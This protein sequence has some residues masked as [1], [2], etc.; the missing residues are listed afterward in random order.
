MLANSL[1]RVYEFLT[2][3][4]AD[5]QSAIR[6]PGALHYVNATSLAKV[7]G[8]VPQLGSHQ[9]LCYCV[10][11]NSLIRVYGFLTPRSADCQTAG[12]PIPKLHFLRS[13]L[14]S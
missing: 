13:R 8:M 12:R 2:P 5:C 10:L 6:M 9:A 1:I 14:D 11:A 4:V 3:R 7:T